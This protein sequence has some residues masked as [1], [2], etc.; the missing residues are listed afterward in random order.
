MSDRPMLSPEQCAVRLGY[1][2]ATI[3]RFIKAG[4]LPAMKIG[5]WRIDPED[6]DKF[7]ADRKVRTA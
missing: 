3:I 1:R 7:I 4:E 5:R 2:P 6:F